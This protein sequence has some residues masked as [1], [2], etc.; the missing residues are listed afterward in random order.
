MK[1]ET[2]LIWFKVDK[3]TE[4]M[5]LY[6]FINFYL[7]FNEVVELYRLLKYKMEWNLDWKKVEDFADKN[8]NN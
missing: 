1:E 4:A 5:Q 2:E 8:E 7:S 6:N 3:N